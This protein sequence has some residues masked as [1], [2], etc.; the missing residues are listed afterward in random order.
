MR[1]ES[2]RTSGVSAFIKE[3]PRSSLVP[4]TVGGHSKKMAIYELG[5][6]PHQTRA[7]R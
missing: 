1:V 3:T 5:S 7:D 6:R 2:S 4:S